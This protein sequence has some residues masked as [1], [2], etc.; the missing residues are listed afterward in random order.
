MA[1]TVT[2]TDGDRPCYNRGCKACRHMKVTN[3]FKSATTGKSYSVCTFATCKTKDII[4]LIECRR[5]ERRPQYVGKTKNALHKHLTHL[6]SD[7]RHN[8]TQKPVSTHFNL[9]GHSMEDLTIMIIEKIETNDDQTRR[10]RQRYWIDKL[11][12]MAPHGINPI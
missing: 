4:Y 12:S 10:T 1:S 9:P 7:I 5:C 2:I 8:R 11:R 3:S 6:R